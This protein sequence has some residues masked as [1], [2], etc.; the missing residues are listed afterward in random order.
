MSLD[1]AIWPILIFY[2]IFLIM[3]IGFIFGAIFLVLFLV[4]DEKKRK[5]KEA[6]K[7]SEEPLKPYHY[8]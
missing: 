6:T 1:V 3:I 4:R 7:I 5:L 2:G 8:E